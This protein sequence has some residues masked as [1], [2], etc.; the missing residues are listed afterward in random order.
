MLIRLLET[1]SHSPLQKGIR[2][3]S[4]KVGRELISKGLAV[5]VK[6]NAIDNVASDALQVA[7]ARDQKQDF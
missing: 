3:V 4:D 5:R 6:E 7:K 2:V 1:D